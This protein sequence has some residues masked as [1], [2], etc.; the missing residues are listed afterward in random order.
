M[1]TTTRWMAEVHEDPGRLA[2]GMKRHPA[3]S[4]LKWRTA[5]LAERPHR[6]QY[7]ATYMS[8]ARMPGAA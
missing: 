3:D 4:Y 6:G 5:G 7:S 8:H 1:A 2:R